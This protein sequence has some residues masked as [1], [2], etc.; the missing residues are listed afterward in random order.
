[1]NKGKQDD[2]SKKFPKKGGVLLGQRGEGRMSNKVEAQGDT[3]KGG[4]QGKKRRPRKRGHNSSST[5]GT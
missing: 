1:V 5:P 2:S 3:P 4:E